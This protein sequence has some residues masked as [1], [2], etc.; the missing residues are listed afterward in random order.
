MQ[1]GDLH[2]LR[3]DIEISSENVSALYCIEDHAQSVD[4][5]VKFGFKVI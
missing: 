2:G 5:A 4:D 1:L 3:Y